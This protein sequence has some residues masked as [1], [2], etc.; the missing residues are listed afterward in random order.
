[1]QAVGTV[2]AAGERDSTSLPVRSDDPTP[3]PARPR[4]VTT[5]IVAKER[6]ER[7]AGARPDTAAAQRALPGYAIGKTV[8]EGGFGKVKEAKHELTGLRVAIK[9]YDKLKIT[10]AADRRRVEREIKI[11]KK[12]NHPNVVR[13]FEVI[14]TPTRLFLVMDLSER[15]SLLDFVKSRKKLTEAV[16]RPMFLQ[17]MYGLQ[18]CHEEDIVHRDIKLENVL[19]DYTGTVRLIDFGL[20]AMASPN[21]WLRVH[22]GSPSYAAPEI[23]GRKSYLGP[24]VDVWSSGIVLF[25]MVC[26]YLPFQSPTGNK[27]ELCE[28][29][30]RGRLKTPDWLSEPLCDLLS[31]MLCKK[32]E[33]RLTIDEVLNHPW[34]RDEENA[35]TYLSFVQNAPLR[36]TQSLVQVKSEK[37][38]DEDILVVLE[39]YGF[40]R[41]D[42]IRS[43]VKG[44]HNYLTTSYY[45]LMMGRSMKAMRGQR[46]DAGDPQ[47]AG[48]AGESAPV[49]PAS[50]AADAQQQ[51]RDQTNK[52][53]GFVDRI[54]GEGQLAGEV[55]DVEA[56]PSPGPADNPDLH[57]ARTDEAQSVHER[58]SL[59]LK[60]LTLAKEEGEDEE[61]PAEGAPRPAAAAS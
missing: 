29:I 59:F 37:H 30:L 14:D 5:G 34:C 33:L 40:G 2:V 1:M 32:P 20:A 38:L 8:G 18:Y 7:L 60:S 50:Q 26:G 19:I 55:L 36:Q 49:Q 13:L 4:P 58:T 9:I 48:A 17:I 25:A 41:D 15:G 16:A 43:L 57:R 35:G 23:V 12:V 42:A 45:L 27:Q 28:K 47:A 39:S 22:C 56:V 52:R 3:G 46:G 54:R 10:E 6:E 24:A 61:E 51:L 31:K 21:K 44:E 53:R 11:L